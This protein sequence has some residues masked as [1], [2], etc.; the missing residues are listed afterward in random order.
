MTWWRCDAWWP[1]WPIKRKKPEEAETTY[2]RSIEPFLWQRLSYDD[3]DFVMTTKIKDVTKDNELIL[4]IGGKQDKLSYFGCLMKSD[5]E[6][7]I[8]FFRLF[9]L[10]FRGEFFRNQELLFAIWFPTHLNLF[11]TK[12]IRFEAPQEIGMHSKLIYFLGFTEWH[13]FYLN[14]R[15]A[16]LACF[17]QVQEIMEWMKL[18][19]S[20]KPPTT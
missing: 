14:A 16:I 6:S 15:D 11:I 3:K 8:G 19:P 9:A 5:S 2:M 4:I 17:N 10:F 18:A 20:K 12:R 7:G 1:Y 13:Q